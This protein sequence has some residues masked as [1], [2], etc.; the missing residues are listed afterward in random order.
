[1]ATDH[2]TL[3]AGTLVETKT[4]PRVFLVVHL[5]EDEGSRVVDLV[6]GA[7]VTFG[8]SRSAVVHVKSDKVSR[9]HTRVMRSRD[10]I[11]IEDLGSRNGTFVNGEKIAAKRRIAVG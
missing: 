10:V 2:L 1:M 5:G 11:E 4:A 3:D 7:E 9:M 8:R 6:D